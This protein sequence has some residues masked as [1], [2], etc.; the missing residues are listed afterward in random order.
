MAGLSQVFETARRSLF[1]QRDAMAVTSHNI[2]NAGTTGYTRQRAELTTTIPLPD[3]VGLL[4]TGVEMS[5][6][7]RLREK[8]I[9]TQYRTTNQQL[10]NASMQSRIF[11]QIEAVVNEPSDNGLQSMMQGFSKAWQSLAATPED[12]GA[13]Q[14]VLQSASTLSNGI[15]QIYSGL[16]QLRSDMKDEISANVDKIN[17]LASE[18]ADFNEK[19]MAA[20]NSNMSANDLMDSRD[21]KIDELSKIANI[22]ATEDNRG[23]MNIS[24]GGVS[25]VN[26]TST[27]PLM[28]KDNVTTLSVQTGPSGNQAQITGG[29]LGGMLQQ[30]NATIPGYQASLD[31]LGQSIMDS[32]NAV[33]SAGYGL[34]ANASDPSAPTGT[35]FF[36][37]YGNGVLMVNAALVTNPSLIAASSTGAAGDNVQA[38]TIANIFDAPTMNGGTVSHN[39][40]FAAFASKIGTDSSVASRD[41]ENQQLI[42]TQMENQRNSFSGVSLDE[43]MTNMIKFQ[44]AYDA[45]AKLVKTVD[46]MMTT[47]IQL[48]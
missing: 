43:E 31:Q 2:A 33:H 11:S 23:A 48:A 32:V 41:E 16:R 17:G 8:F 35:A 26:Q 38:N 21:L 20:S 12:M 1:A 30:Y 37:S 27:I 7:S 18:I 40:F 46:E 47:I 22:R 39:Q 42:L 13:R 10:N 14:I 9:D 19:I 5:S 24:V 36:T 6:V 34:K 44:R 25:I 4:G 15:Q 45:S 3:R 28:L 29:E